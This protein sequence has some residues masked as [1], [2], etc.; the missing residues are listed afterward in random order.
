MAW[1]IPHIMFTKV[2]IVQADYVKQ[3]FFPGKLENGPEIPTTLFLDTQTGIS[4]ET[5]AGVA[6]FWL[7]AHGTKKARRKGM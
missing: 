7:H 6:L 2:S 5:E 1:P 4:Y 3:I